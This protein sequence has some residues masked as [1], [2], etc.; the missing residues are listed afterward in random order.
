MQVKKTVNKIVARF[1]CSIRGMGEKASPLGEDFSLFMCSQRIQGSKGSRIQ[2]KPSAVGHRQA[3]GCPTDQEQR[4]ENLP[5]GSWTPWI[6]EPQAF[7]FSRRLLTAR[8]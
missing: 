6:L 3:V 8:L 5:L 1:Y 2:V 7:G 4:A